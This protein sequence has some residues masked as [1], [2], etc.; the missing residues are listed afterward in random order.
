M[1]TAS[2][3]NFVAGST[4][5]MHADREG[6]L[7]SNA[8]LPRAFVS[9]LR[10]REDHARV[11]QL[12]AGACIF[13]SSCIQAVQVPF[14]HSLNFERCSSR[15]RRRKALVLCRETRGFTP[16]LNV[17]AG[18][19]QSLH[20][21]RVSFPQQGDESRAFRGAPIWAG[22]NRDLSAPRSGTISEKSSAK[23]LPRPQRTESDSTLSEGDFESCPHHRYAS[24]SCHCTC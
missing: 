17:C 7:V 22:S 11:Q 19:N 18:S 1:F 24:L 13:V 20:L 3:E 5:T 14:L 6:N 9:Y 8:L 12:H 21:R 23:R 4:A 15:S 16:W 10:G 2:Y